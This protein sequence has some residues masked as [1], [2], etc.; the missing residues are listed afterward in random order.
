MV[1]TRDGRFIAVGWNTF[2]MLGLGT[3]QEQR[4]PREVTAIS[5]A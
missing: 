3:T 1:V 4:E 2:G 5:T